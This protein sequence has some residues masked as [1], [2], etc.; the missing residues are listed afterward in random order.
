MNVHLRADVEDAAE[1][2]PAVRILDAVAVDRVH[3]AVIVA[4]RRRLDRTPDSERRFLVLLRN[5]AAPRTTR[6]RG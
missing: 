6:G 2:D 5:E 4:R 3:G 1:L